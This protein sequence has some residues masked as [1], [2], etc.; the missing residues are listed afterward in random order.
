VSPSAMVPSGHLSP[1]RSQC[2]LFPTSAISCPVEGPT[3]M[4]RTTFG[5]PLFTPYLSFY[6][7]VAS[8]PHCDVRTG[9]FRPVFGLWSSFSFHCPAVSLFFSCF[10]SVPCSLLPIVVYQCPNLLLSSP[11]LW[12]WRFFCHFFH[13]LPCLFDVGFSALF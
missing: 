5:F 2:L 6:L 11:V 10:C 4:P 9:V 1:A 7:I 13:P 8:D 3:E 12:P